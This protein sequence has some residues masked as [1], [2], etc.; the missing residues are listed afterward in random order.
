MTLLF[1]YAYDHRVTGG[2]GSVESSWTVRTLSPLLSW[3]VDGA[4][5][6][7]ADAGADAGGA[8]ALGAGFAALRVGADAEGAAARA[9]APPALPGMLGTAV[10]CL[11][12]ALVF[13]YL[14]R[15]DLGAAC[16]SDAVTLLM[17]GR[18][19]ALRALLHVRRL[20]AHGDDDSEMHYLLNTLVV[21]DYCAWLQLLPSD[22]LLASAAAALAAATAPPPAGPLDRSLLLPWPLADLEARAADVVAAADEAEAAAAAAAGDSGS[23]DGRSSDEGSDSDA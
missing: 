3:L 21:D 16:L 7:A 11:R 1:A 19:A 5:G 14:R 12:R 17:C 9:S 4:H 22:E 8:A 6:E 15:W 10:A 13:P 18:R 2:E 20:L 23:D